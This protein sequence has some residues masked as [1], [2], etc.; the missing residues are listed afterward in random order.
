MS[1][2]AIQNLF[3]CFSDQLK[4]TQQPLKNLKAI[5]ALTHCRTPAMGVS[6]YRCQ[7][8]CSGLIQIDTSM[9]DNRPS[10]A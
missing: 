9:R 8:N 7:S 10:L 4:K 6:Y 2:R 3:F 5:D 1:N